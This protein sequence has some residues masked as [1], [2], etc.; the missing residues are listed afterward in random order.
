MEIYIVTLIV[1]LFLSVFSYQ[2]VYVE[3]LGVCDYEKLNDKY[4]KLFILIAVFMLL[5]VGLRADII[6]IDTLNYKDTYLNFVVAGLCC[7]YG[8]FVYYSNNGFDFQK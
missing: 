2:S 1:C 7:V 4:K 6:G 8:V 3:R 5:I